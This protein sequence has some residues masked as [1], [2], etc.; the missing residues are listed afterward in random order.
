[1]L[2]SLG[3]GSPGLYGHIRANA[4]K[5]AVLLVG[6]VLLIC[7][8]WF[9][10]C[11]AY[12]ALDALLWHWVRALSVEDA[13][14]EIASK[15]F[16]LAALRWYVPFV[17]ASVWFACAWT[18][19]RRLIQMAT[20]AQPIDRRSES[21][22]Y[23]LVENL[24]ITAGLPMPRVEIIETGELNAYAA[25]LSPRDATI[26]VTRG[27]LMRLT[28]DELEAVLA[29]EM[30]HIKNRDV[31]LMVV[32]LIFSGG[33]TLIGDFVS[34]FGSRIGITGN[35]VFAASRLGLSF[36]GGGRDGDS[37]TDSGNWL[38][39]IAAALV[40]VLAIVMMGMA[41]I[42]AILSQFS[43]SRSREF[44][45]D[46]GAVEL[47]KN[48]DALISALQK[49]SA[50]DDIP[51]ASES[52]RAMM[53]SRGFD[54]E[55]FVDELFA[56]HPAVEK[57]ISALALHAGGRVAAPRQARA[58]GLRPMEGRATLAPRPAASAFTGPRAQFGRRGA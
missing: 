30:T 12:A 5:T 33:I 37:E 52:M 22:L 2:G 29:H 46:G 31:R 53:F 19:Y 21:K 49:I 48:P 11:L 9:G 25:G 13:M 16:A 23:N 58:G 41:H 18:F 55:G 32:A 7:C 54:G 42:F 47:T 57:R 45:A 8:Y 38:G 27:L 44:M 26:A 20:G 6:F 34:A 17:V 1:M 24:A 51:L 40:F 10:A 4:F 39:F 56:T 14:F 15:G 50:N 28:K 3:L 43:I 36:A 35:E